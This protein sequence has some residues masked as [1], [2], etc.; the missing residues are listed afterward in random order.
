M[1]KSP[2]APPAKRSSPDLLPKRRVLIFVDES[3]VTSSAK[4]ANR[5]L[6]WL[7]LRDH[8]VQERE[9]IEMV[10]Y[11][12][13]PPAMTEWQTER[14]KKNKF[15]FWLRSHGFLVVEKDGSPAD[16]SHYKANVDVLM[17]IDAI[18]LST[19]MQPDVVILVTGD[20]DFAHLALQLRRRGIRVEVASLAQTLGSAL[21]T[22]ANEIIDLAPILATFDP[23]V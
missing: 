8:L 4:T 17:A 10:V 5:K 19:Q 9:L 1:T 12:G 21:K 11:A 15:L 7:A 6:D 2:S 20:A 22:S 18:E 14:D 23:L 13:L 16:A 3:N